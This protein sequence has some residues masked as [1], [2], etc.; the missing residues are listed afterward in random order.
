MAKKKQELFIDINNEKEFN[1][2]LDHNL[3]NIVCAEV[4]CSFSGP[5]TALDRLF[6]RIKLDWSDG[7]M[8]LLRVLADE[9]ESLTRF[10]NQSEPIFLFILNKKITRIFRGVD[11]VKFAD[12]AKKEIEL[13]KQRQEGFV[14]DRLTFELNESSPEEIEWQTKRNMETLQE[15][16][17]QHARR[18]ARQAARKRHRAELMVPHLQQLNFV[19][20]WPHAI[21]A[22]PE[23]YERWDMNNIIMVGREETLLDYDTALDVLYAGD[24]PIN[25]ASMYMLTSAPALAICFRI[26]DPDKHFV[27]IVRNILYEDVSPLDDTKTFDKNIQERSAFDIYKTYSPT[28][29]EVWQKRREERLRKKEEAIE[30]RTRRLSEMQR[31][32]RQ[33]IADELE[34]RRFDKEHR[35]LQLLKAGNLEALEELQQEPDDEEVDIVVPDELSDEEESSFEEDENEYFPPPGLIVPGFYAPP[36]DIAKANG[37]AVLFPKLVA[38]HVT[39]E[40]EYL[41]PHVLVLLDIN[42]R[43]KAIDALVKYRSAIIH[44]GIFQLKTPYDAKHLAY[45]V[46]Q[47]DSIN[48]WY[49]L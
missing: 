42:K 24:A 9:I 27:S 34:A 22:H 20:Y 8:V 48:S 30:K 49:D 38:E 37:L 47:F 43:H 17:A 1:N 7:K 3:D 11:N 6:V 4:F 23:L 2:I 10:Q 28:K 5:C 46:K 25:E 32:A 40:P 15:A 31:L 33:A 39:P 29:E 41:P 16:N 12:V 44:M 14:F 35:K 13:Y 18:A 36:N 19:L 26:L 45:S 21:H